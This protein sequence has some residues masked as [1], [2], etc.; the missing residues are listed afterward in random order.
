VPRAALVA[1]KRQRCCTIKTHIARLAAAGL[2]HHGWQQ[3]FGRR[4][5]VPAVPRQRQVL[6]ITNTGFQ[7]E[8]GCDGLSAA[9]AAGC[10]ALDIPA[11]ARTMGPVHHRPE[12]IEAGRAAF[13]LDDEERARF[14]AI[15]RHGKNA[16]TA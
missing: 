15:L 16:R 4:Q 5:P 14:R 8:A 1:K 3:L 9:L 13:G 7:E 11:D 10:P 6:R 12:G 2:L